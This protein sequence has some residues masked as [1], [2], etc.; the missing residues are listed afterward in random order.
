[1][2]KFKTSSNNSLLELRSLLNR[3]ENLINKDYCHVSELLSP[4]FLSMLQNSINQVENE[5]CKREDKGEL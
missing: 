4:K 5:V 1:M 2:N 3:I